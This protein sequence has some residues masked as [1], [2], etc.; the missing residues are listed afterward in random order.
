MY[1]KLASTL[2]L[3]SGAAE[4][5]TAVNMTGFNAVT[6][7][8]ELISLGMAGTLNIWVQESNDAEFWTDGA[9]LTGLTAIGST[10]YAPSTLIGSQ[11]V[12]LRYDIGGTGPM[13]FSAGLMQSSQ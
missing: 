4:R 11:F 12:R 7:D 10:L 6:V 9:T 2:A 3:A 8:A 1:T 13:C 5:S